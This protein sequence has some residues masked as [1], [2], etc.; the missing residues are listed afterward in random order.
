MYIIAHCQNITK[1]FSHRP[2]KLYTERHCKCRACFAQSC[3]YK[4]TEPLYHSFKR[5]TIFLAAI[6]SFIDQ[7]KNNL[8]LKTEPGAVKLDEV[9]SVG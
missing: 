9:P 6:N 1:H 4:V 3:R 5:F 7:L 2:W 8:L